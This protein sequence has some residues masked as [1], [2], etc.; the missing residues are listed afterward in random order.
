VVD[1]LTEEVL[2][3]QPHHVRQFLT[4]TSILERF[5]ATLCDSVAGTANAAKVI[6]LLER[7][8]LFLVP[9]DDDRQWYR[10][11]HLFAQM[12]RSQLARTE[13]EIVPELHRRASAWHRANGSAEEAIRHALASDDARGAVDMI[14]RYWYEF[15]FAGRAGTVRRW[16]RFLGDDRIRADPV[17][18][19]VAAVV[20]ALSGDRDSV[21]Q[22][23]P[24]IEAA[25]HEGPL[26]DGMRSLRFSAA[27]IRAAWGYDG[28]SAMRAAAARAVELEPDPASR[29]YP[30]AWLSLGWSLFLSGEPGAAAALER[31]V[32]SE[33]SVPLI[34]MVTLGTA[35]LVAHDEGKTGQ[36]EGFANAARQ[37]AD[38]S[39][40]NDAPQSSVVW[41]ALGMVHA[42]RGELEEARAA[43][44]HA[45]Q[46]RRRYFGISPWYTADAL[47]RL[48]ALLAGAGEHAEAAALLAEARDLLTSMPDGTENQL[49]RL[50]S[51][52][53]RLTARPAVTGLAQPLTERE[54]AVLRL[55]RGPL[56]LREIGQ[57]LFLSANTI[58][59]HTRAIYRKLGV[60]TRAGAVE[61]GHEAG[62]L[63]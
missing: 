11:H 50:R 12:L 47:L 45:V 38:N 16:L 49:A 55:L 37:I 21:R 46:S 30:M 34:R 20:A 36:A 15:V 1:F 59:S 42:H 58:K 6:D 19:H 5:T 63:S 53:A 51:L 22:W 14:A 52:E 39:G 7:E 29:W 13:P 8:N 27:V 56:S 48:A 9:L 17:A 62:L 35:S 26:P 23:L 43:L 25:Q 40:L 24:V 61:R 28:I 41:S 4:R 44:E 57:E 33:S 2:S 10:Y 32:L 18:A 31:A 54:T 3:R 60:S